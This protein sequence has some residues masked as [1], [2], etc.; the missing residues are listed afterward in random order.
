MLKRALAIGIDAYAHIPLSACGLDARRIH[1]RLA[2]HTDDSPNFESRLVT[3]P[4]YTLDRT[5]LLELARRALM[6]EADVAL[7]YFAGHGGVDEKGGY[8]LAQDSKDGSDGIR[9]DEL[10]ALANDSPVREVIILLDCCSAGAFA[11]VSE[12]KSRAV[13]D[14]GL[15]VI[16]AA[17]PT[18]KAV[19]HE[20]GGVFTS[21]LCEALDGG[22]AD[23]R[24][25]VTMASAYAYLDESL[26]AW[27]QR[28]QL[29]AHVSQLVQLRRCEPA[30]PD[31]LLRKLA[32]WFPKAHDEYPLSRA[33]EPTQDPRDPE[34]EAIFS[35]LQRCRAAKLVEPVGFDHMYDAAM[36]PKGA[37]RLT[38]LGRHY[39]QM[40]RRGRI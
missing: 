7:L 2:T 36:A 34:K 9:M 33:H 25:W 10:L 16:A 4:Q 23:V 5:T 30:V 39:H 3:N 15:T 13:L 21:V 11:N 37:C 26:G 20:D 19:E 35:V 12:L 17:R 32:K 38:P 29:K 14:H 28:P 40:V 22:A 8:I 31:E 18:E 1:E 27:D 6:R 24:G